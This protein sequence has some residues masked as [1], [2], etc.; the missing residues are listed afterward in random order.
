MKFNRCSAVLLSALMLAQLAACGGKTDP[1][2][3]T[4]GEPEKVVDPYEGWVKDDLPADLRF[5]GETFTIFRGHPVEGYYMEEE[6]GDVV[7]DAI[8][9]RNVAVEERFGIDLNILDCPYG[10][11]GGDQSTAT[12][13]IANFILAGDS[14]NDIYIHVQHTGM[15]EQI[16]SGYYR[17]WNE[18]PYFDFTKDYWYSK[19]LTDINYY[20]KV[21]AMTGSYNL[22][23]LTIANCLLFNKRIC[24]DLHLDYPY[25]M[26][27][28]GTWTVDKW[29]EYLK[30][31]SKDLDGDTA[32]SFK[33]D[34]PD[35]IAWWGWG[36]E[37]IPAL[38]MGLGGD[39]VK[40]LADGSPELNINNERTVTVVEKMLDVFAIPGCTWIYNDSGLNTSM[41]RAQF[42]AGRCFFLHGGLNNTFR[43]MADDYGYVPYPKLDASQESYCARVQNT[44]CLTYIP[45]TN[46]RDELTSAVLEYMA[47]YSHNTIVPAYFDVTLTIK[48][49]RDT[50]S[51]EMIPIIR[52]A[53]TFNDEAC[54]FSIASCVTSN[55]GLA[56]VYA[57]QESALKQKL[58][59][60]IIS[61]YN[62]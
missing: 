59:D 28:D 10:S 2:V 49:T 52:D 36:Y 34:S 27:K 29:M 42:N 54:S 47:M 44:S 19:C 61:A 56:S 1:S 38:F 8:Y 32:I 18:F 55:Q 20:D 53:C 26:V 41:I 4:T 62:K 16:A 57:S 40:K 24:D 22:S 33:Q 35:Q 51:E 39:S 9:Q 30:V 37:S 31:G 21:Y 58:Q 46:T 7:D 11:G 13:A 15:P 45:V 23:T 6:T 50:E 48:G 25:Q 3:T 17:D 14:T 43:D 5:D 60:N 12:S